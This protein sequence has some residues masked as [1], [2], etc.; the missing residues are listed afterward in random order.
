MSSLPDEDYQPTSSKFSPFIFTKPHSEE[1]DVEGLA[2]GKWIEEKAD[3]FPELT[4][5]KKKFDD[6]LNVRITSF[7]N[8]A[9]TQE[10]VLLYAKPTDSSQVQKLVKN[11]LEIN[12]DGGKGLKVM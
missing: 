1:A 10:C 9:G 4:K 8:W 5:L 3:L 11:V 7:K 12:K 6:N 2:D